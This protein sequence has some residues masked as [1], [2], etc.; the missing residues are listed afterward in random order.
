[1]HGWQRDWNDF[2]AFGHQVKD[3]STLDKNVYSVH[4]W[5][6]LEDKIGVYC[7]SLFLKY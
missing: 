3:L 7:L 2:Y 5:P 4:S 1:M 6:S